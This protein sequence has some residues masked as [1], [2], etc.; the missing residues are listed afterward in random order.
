MDPAAQPI[1]A[2]LD[3]A[4]RPPMDPA[5]QP[6]AAELDPADRPLAAELDPADRPI[7][8][9]GWFDALP[10]AAGR[11]DGSCKP[12][13]CSLSRNGYGTHRKATW[14][15]A[16]CLGP[17]H[18]PSDLF[19]PLPMPTTIPPADAWCPCCT[20]SLDLAQGIQKR[21]M[22][23]YVQTGRTI[24]GRCHGTIGG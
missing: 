6:I 3:P 11:L 9:A 1:A 4:D 5:A 2:E 19:E 18:R 15:I 21:S 7:A 20:G 12:C 13:P 8:A 14:G 22:R 17:F 24:L 10:K 16:W 23:Y